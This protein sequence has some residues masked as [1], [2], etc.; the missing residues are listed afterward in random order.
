MGRGVDRY[1]IVGTVNQDRQVWEHKLHVAPRNIVPGDG[2]FAGYNRCTPAHPPC[3][4]T[5]INTNTNTNPRIRTSIRLTY[6]MA[7][8]RTVKLCAR[9]YICCGFDARVW[10][11]G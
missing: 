2:P 11:L 3:I 10:Y 9:L 8:P 6:I 4:R 7:V 1:F 5:H